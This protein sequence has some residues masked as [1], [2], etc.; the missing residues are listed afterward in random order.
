MRIKAHVMWVLV[1]A[2]VVGATQPAHADN[3]GINGVVA[4]GGN[5]EENDRAAVSAGVLQAARVAGW[6]L[7]AKALSKKESA[8]LLRCLEPGEPWGCIPSSIGAQGIYHALVIGAVRQQSE[9][10][11]PLVVLTGKLVVTKPRALVVHQRFCE[12]PTDDKLTRESAD[13]AQQLVQELAVRIGRTVLDV[14]STPSGAQITLDG[15][16]IGATSTTYNTYPGQH[17]VVLEKAG[18]VTQT[19][20][21]DAEEGKTATLAVTLRESERV[22]KQEPITSPQSPSRRLPLALFGVGGVGVVTSGVLIY[23]GQQDGTE[24]KYL[25]SRAT[26]IGVV[27]GIAGV[28]AIATGAYL[29]W[30]GPSSSTPTVT[31]ASGVAV[32]GWARSF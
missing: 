11:R 29:W 8:A 31:A 14:S 25:R 7:P 4:V 28:A 32:V 17:I 19:H 15:A 26:T 13:L 16:A 9:D 5:A 1:L 23:I 12:H 18:Y 6:Q 22:T 30:R 3:K 2:L 10:G 27:S 20:T 21:I 24:D